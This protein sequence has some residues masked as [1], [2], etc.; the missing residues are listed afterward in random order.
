MKPSLRQTLRLDKALQNYGAPSVAIELKSRPS[1]IRM[2]VPV[3]FAALLE[4]RRRHGDRFT[5]DI[6]DDW[7]QGRTTFGGLIA[8]L[9]V[10]AMRDVT[11]GEWPL[12]ALQASFVAPVANDVK[13]LVHLLRQGRSIRQ[14]QATLTSQGHVAAVLLGVFGQA[15]AWSLPALHA[16]RPP[17]AIA[18]EA[19]YK[20]PFVEG[21]VPNFLVHLDARWAEGDLPYAGGEHWHSKIHL[22]LRDGAAD[23]E[24]TSVLLADV[25]P[26]PAVGQLTQQAPASSV[27]WE[28]ELVPAAAP[29]D[30]TDWWRVD[31][32]AIAAADGYVNQRTTLW[33]PDGT[34][35]ALGY[36][37]AAVYG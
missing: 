31:T 37:V 32:V 3:P 33:A 18:P 25:P 21:E 30:L 11:G 10:D 22:R 7:R 16:Q 5:Y 1:E 2:Q 13:V 35:A 23:P 6:T 4:R 24:L 8:A 36:Q 27:S 12:R 17:V 29:Y 26:T 9:G 20:R 15:R 19:A 28:L 34:L 14:V